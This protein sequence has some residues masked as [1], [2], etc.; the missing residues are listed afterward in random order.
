[1]TTNLVTLTLTRGQL[2]VM[3]EHFA[4]AHANLV[5][6]PN[7]PEAVESQALLNEVRDIVSTAVKAEK[8][9]GGNTEEVNSVKSGEVDGSNIEEVDSVNSEEID[10]LNIEEADSVK[11]EEVDGGNT[12]EVNGSN[13]AEVN[14]GNT[15]EVNRGNTAEANGGNIEEFGVAEQ[16]RRALINN[17]EYATKRVAEAEA[18]IDKATEGIAR[19]AETLTKAKDEM[20]LYA[21]IKDNVEAREANKVVHRATMQAGLAILQIGI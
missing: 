1:M 5:A 16:E 18:R 2:H 17:A 12:E 11:S 13:T 14:R 3:L 4:A 15:A 20:T 6:K 7:T 9:D 10:G 8:V 19:A 21:E